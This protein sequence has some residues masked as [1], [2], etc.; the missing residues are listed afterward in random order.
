LSETSDCV[1]Y[2][3]TLADYSRFDSEMSVV[4]VVWQDCKR[5]IEAY[6][7]QQV[8]TAPLHLSV[9]PSVCST[10]QEHEHV[11]LW[12]VS[13][14]SVWQNFCLY[15]FQVQLLWRDHWDVMLHRSSV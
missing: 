7:E 5:L 4:S 6:N 11:C 13:V 2:D 9:C 12:C 1:Q 15:D 14:L 3:K 8:Y 10:W